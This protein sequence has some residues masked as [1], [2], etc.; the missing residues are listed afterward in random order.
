MKPSHIE[1]LPRIACELIE[2]AILEENY[3]NYEELA[4]RFKKIGKGISKSSLH[5]HGQKLKE[6]RERARFEAEVMEQMG[7]D[8]AY[9][10]RWARG[11]PKAAARLVARLQKQAASDEAR[12]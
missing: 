12:R 1:T 3:S 8:A 5:R 11:N 2:R 7:G 4:A 6:R 9:L 10:V